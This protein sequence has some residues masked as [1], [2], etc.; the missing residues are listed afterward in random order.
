[1]FLCRS[2]KDTDLTYIKHHE[3]EV[4]YV[5]D[6]ITNMRNP[7]EVE[8]NMANGKVATA[9]ISKDM[10][11]AQEIGEQKSTTFI[12]E[13]LLDEEPVLF[14]KLECYSCSTCFYVSR[15]CNHSQP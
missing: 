9:N 2:H 10:T 8:E 15:P 13:C 14:V 11:C 6:T 7:F 4:G 3:Q 1:M 5:V 12:N